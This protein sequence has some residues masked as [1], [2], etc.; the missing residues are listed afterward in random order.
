MNQHLERERKAGKF[1]A[2]LGIVCLLM[3]I[4]PLYALANRVEPFVLGLPFSMFWVVLWI[5]IEFV[6]FVA[7][8]L[9]EYRGR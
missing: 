6:G 4:Y 1:I 3:L 2:V 5:L 8:Y 9:W 7:A